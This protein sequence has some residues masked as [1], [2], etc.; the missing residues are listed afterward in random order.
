[1]AYEAKLGMSLAELDTPALLLDL[2]AL[3]RNIAKM[4]AFFAGQKTTLRPH[5]KTHKS[6]IIAQ[7][8][9]GAGAMGITCAKLS[10]AEVMAAAGIR[11][12]LIA[13]QVVGSVK[14]GRLVELAQR[15]DL[16][17]AVDDAQNVAQLARACAAQGVSLRVLVEVD[18]GMGRCGVRPGEPALALAQQ[19]EAAPAL[20]LKGLM[21]YEGHLVLLDDPLQRAQQ[22][23][24]A[25]APL[26]RSADLLRQNGLSVEI[27]SA[28]GTGTYADTGL[29]PFITEMQCGSYVFMDSTYEKVRDEFELALTILTTVASRPAPERLVVDAGLK[30]LSRELGLPRPLDVA[31]LAVRHLSEE[32]GVLD[33]L[34]SERVDYRPGDKLRLVPSHCCTTVN[35]FDTY[36]VIQDGKLVDLWPIA[37]R[38]RSQ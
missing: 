20:A 37:A 12:I 34:E 21:G 10:E 38:G 32:H 24:A 27:V 3:D 36:H 31:G 13:N 25:F 15:C 23:Q 1:M 4:S 8:Q 2:D 16:M 7:R 33:V 26:K 29:L 11:D 17:V 14:I 6:P 9:L 19:V 35:L 5:I 28:G 18:V 30:T 22:V